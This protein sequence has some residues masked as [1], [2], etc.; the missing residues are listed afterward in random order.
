[1]RLDTGSPLTGTIRRLVWTVATLVLL[2]YVA[3]LMIARTDGFRH[4][5]EQRLRSRWNEPALSIGR[6]RLDPLGILMLDDLQIT[7]T[8]QTEP[9]IR[10][11]AVQWSWRLAGIMHRDQRA[12]R[13]IR[14]HG[15]EITMTYPPNG[16][17]VT[18]PFAADAA[19]LAE[20]LGLFPGERRDVSAERHWLDRS[21]TVWV[22]EATLRWQGADGTV[23]AALEGI[24]YR[25][26]IRTLQERLVR[27]EEATVRHL[28]SPGRHERD[29]HQVWLSLDDIPF[30]PAAT[31]IQ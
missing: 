21:Q 27:L 2:F 13:M 31:V 15:A 19:F 30:R 23:Q 8:D 28:I 7:A 1:M 29:I 9:H 11:P 20:Q 14:V 6:V 26:S 12:F 4:L 5:L 24:T 25:A 10:I 16:E 18:N 17:Q 22:E 3:T